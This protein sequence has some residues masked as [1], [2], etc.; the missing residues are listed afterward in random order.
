MP[1]KLQ[2]R[3]YKRKRRYGSSRYI[4]VRQP[5]NVFKSKRVP[6]V[7]VPF[8]KQL[9][10]KLNYADTK[11]LL[12][13]GPGVLQY[14]TYRHNNI[15]D[16][17]QT[18]TGA[19]VYYN[20]Q[21]APIYGSFC[22]YG[23]KIHIEATSAYNCNTPVKILVRCRK[24]TAVPT[25]FSL[26]EERQMS[27]YVLLPPNGQQTK[28]LTMYMST[29]AV[30]GKT[31]KQILSSPDYEAPTSSSSTSAISNESFWTVVAYPMDPAFTV[32]AYINVKLT[33]YTKFYERLPQGRS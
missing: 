11:L 22:V 28:T 25:D 2:S 19:Q 9:F 20:D 15:T 27:R 23:C 6:S 10:T 31:K 7:Q 8:P 16:P 14:Q 1:R 3:P 13:S 18:S 4:S 12:G 30:F 29:G 5:G 32:A 24:S 26:E 33:Y 17:D 21:L